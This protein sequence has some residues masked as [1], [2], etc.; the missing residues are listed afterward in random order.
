MHYRKLKAYRV[1]RTVPVD[2]FAMQLRSEITEADPRTRLGVRPKFIP[3][4]P[5]LCS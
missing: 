3:I 5:A 4:T 2:E 1:S